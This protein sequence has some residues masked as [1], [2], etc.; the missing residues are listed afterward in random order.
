VSVN[1]CGSVI[2]AEQVW[3]VRNAYV[4]WMLFLCRALVCIPG[5]LEFVVVEVTPH[6]IHAASQR[7]DMSMAS[8]PLRGT[9]WSLV[10]SLSP[11]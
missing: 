8:I 11:S 3:L 10:Q 1:E 4:N 2:D 9:Y 7:M 6:G 5:S